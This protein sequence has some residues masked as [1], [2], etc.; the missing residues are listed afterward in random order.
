LPA[1]WTRRSVREPAA[2]AISYL[3][4]VPRAIGAKRTAR[5]T[6]GVLLEPE[7]FE[8]HELATRP[9]SKGVSTIVIISVPTVPAGAT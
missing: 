3:P 4:S 5:T 1:P 2:P 7:A 8:Q 6:V 9:A